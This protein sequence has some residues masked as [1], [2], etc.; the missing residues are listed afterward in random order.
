MIPVVL[1]ASETNGTVDVTNKY[2]W[3]ENI[4]WINF[5]TSGG[6]VAITDAGLT[7]YAWS[8]NY[9]WIFLDPSGSG[10]SNNAEGTLSGQAWGENTGFIDFS[11]VTIDSSGLFSG[12]ASGTVTGQISFNCSNSSSCGS[13]DFK[14]GTD[15]R[16]ASTRV[17]DDPGSGGGGGGGIIGGGG[18]GGGGIGSILPPHI[19]AFNVPLII[20]ASQSGTLI[21]N[22]T[23]DH[24]L[25]VEVP[26]ASVTSEIT[27]T[28]TWRIVPI[29]EVS[30]LTSADVVLVSNDVFRVTAVDGNNNPVTTFLNPIT[31]TITIPDMPAD[32][33]SVGLYFLDTE[34]SVWT[35]V[36]DATFS[37]QSVVFTVDHLTDFAIFQIEELPSFFAGVAALFG[38][39][40]LPGQLPALFKNS[41]IDEDGDTDI[42][43][44]NLL[45]VHWGKRPSGNVALLIGS[46]RWELRAD[47]DGN[48]EVDIF[49]FNQLLVEW[50]G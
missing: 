46:D 29:G 17:Q 13:S 40:A 38:L 43:D 23:S 44:F 11:G 25:Q 27:I 12:H 7:G 37:D 39:E 10:V 31:I 24:E 47:I 6:S 22:F 48:G 41:D 4:G 28:V 20:E 49:D 32:R 30:E 26:T 8:D 36:P 2:A 42:F 21:R 34:N 33:S 3:S 14:V 1:F 19:N 35:L 50:T 9:G 18:G 16:P 5:G 15:W 45:M